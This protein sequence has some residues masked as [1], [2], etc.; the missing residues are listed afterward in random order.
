[1]SAEK[2]L[3]TTRGRTALGALIPKDNKWRPF[4]PVLH[5]NDLDCPHVVHVVSINNLPEFILE[6]DD[7]RE[8]D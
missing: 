5:L 1:M 7:L 8:W 4:T 2:Y 6:V 3:Q